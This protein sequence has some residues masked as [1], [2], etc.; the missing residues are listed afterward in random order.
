[1]IKLATRRHSHCAEVMILGVV[2][3]CEELRVIDLTL[4]PEVEIEKLNASERN[5]MN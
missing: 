3:T 5:K 4:L 1:V 2:L